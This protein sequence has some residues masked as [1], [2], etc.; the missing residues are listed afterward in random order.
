MRTELHNTSVFAALKRGESMTFVDGKACHAMKGQVSEMLTRGRL[1]AVECAR[2]KVKFLPRQVMRPVF[3]KVGL[4]HG[5]LIKHRPS[6][7][8]VLD[9]QSQEI[10]NEI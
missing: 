1:Y 9:V 10:N 8:F 5:P 4:E 3:A 2:R 6:D 7:L